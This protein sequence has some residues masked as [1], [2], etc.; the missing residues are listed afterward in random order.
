MIMMIWA[1][2]SGRRGQLPWFKIISTYNPIWCTAF[3]STGQMRMVMAGWQSCVFIHIGVTFGLL[4]LSAFLLRRL[5]KREGEPA[6]SAMAMPVADAA[7]I[8]ALMAEGVTETDAVLPPAT[9]R[10]GSTRPVGDN[11]I[12]WR[13]LRRPLMT[14]TWQRIA[15]ALVCIALMILTYCVLYSNNDLKDSDTQVG[16]AIVAHALMMLLACVISATAI[17]AEKESDTWTI[18]LASP[19][20]GTNIMWSKAAGVVRRLLWP[21]VGIAVHF[22]FFV[23]GGVITPVTFVMI[24]VVVTSF[25]A[26]WVATGV[27]LSLFCRKVTIAVIIN[28]ALPVVLYGVVSILLAVFDELFHISNGHLA[29]GVT[30]YLPFYYLAAGISR[31][32]YDLRPELPGYNSGRVSQSEF[33]A[34]AMA[35]GLLHL[36]VASVILAI[37]S[38][39]FNSAV[40]RA[41]QIEPL[42]DPLPRASRTPS[43]AVQSS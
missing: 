40:G 26:I 13:E 3:L 41:S 6:A 17:A 12:L 9:V 30:W 39:A 10:T 35:F 18:L 42:P 14:S 11:P 32:N 24:L 8:P 23:I 29:E 25:N 5:A 20:S 19:V 28:L 7:P 1:S 37:A 34:V 43:W 33:L 22:S 38:S 36:V 2:G 31:H 4:L 21:T 16:Y 27:T 15:G